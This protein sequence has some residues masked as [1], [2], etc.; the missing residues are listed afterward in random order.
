M[1]AAAPTA[2]EERAQREPPQ[3]EEPGEI[4]APAS[5]DPK[6]EGAPPSPPTQLAGLT[7]D[8]EEE[9]REEFLRRVARAKKWRYSLVEEK[10]RAVPALWALW[11]EKDEQEEEGDEEPEAPPRKRKAEPIAGAKAP[12]PPPSPVREPP[13]AEEPAAKRRKQSPL[14]EHV[15]AHGEFPAGTARAVMDRECANLSNR[16]TTARKK[17][18]GDTAELHAWNEA[19]LNAR[20]KAVKAAGAD[21]EH[22]AMESAQARMLRVERLTNGILREVGLGNVELIDMAHTAQTLHEQRPAG[23]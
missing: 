23:R 21:A 3:G 18:Q 14:L 10:L 15:L 17:H 5:P 22:R 6:A 7:P 20:K 13:D 16:V 8:P 19:L 9:T 1:A 2:E 4:Q 11:P 12:K